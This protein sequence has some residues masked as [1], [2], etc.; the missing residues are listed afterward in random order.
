MTIP[1]SSTDTDTENGRARHDRRCVAM[2]VSLVTGFALVL[3]AVAMMMWSTFARYVVGS[4]TV[5]ESLER[6]GVSD[7]PWFWW[8]VA[9]AVLGATVAAVG[10]RVFRPCGAHAD[11]G[12]GWQ[13]PHDRAAGTVVVPVDPP[14]K[15][16]RDIGRSR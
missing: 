8:V 10:V 6:P 12:R 1:S 14:P 13:G 3:P 16:P 4:P 11:H 9:L 5:G 15:E 2:H 7:H